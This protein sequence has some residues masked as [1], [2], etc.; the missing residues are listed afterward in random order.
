MNINLAKKCGFIEISSE[1]EALVLR[2]VSIFGLD[3]AGID[4]LDDGNEI[5]YVSEI[6]PEPNCAEWQP[7]FGEKI[8]QS[9]FEKAQVN[10]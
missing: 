4:L 9:Y 2:V 5:P 1:V 10:Q 6:N 7:D 3:V 8:A